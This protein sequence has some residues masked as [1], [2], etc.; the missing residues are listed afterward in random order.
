MASQGDSGGPAVD[1]RGK[2]VG[3]V[4]FGVGCADPDYD[5]VYTN[6]ANR[7]VRRFIDYALRAL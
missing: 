4:S 3:I 7:K 2:Q 5:G 6:L 1:K